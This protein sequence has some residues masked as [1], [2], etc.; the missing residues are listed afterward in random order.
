MQRLVINL[1]GPPEI[2]L[3]GESLETDRHKAIGLL[4]YLATEDKTNSREAL[5]ALLWPDYPQQ[6]AFSYLRRT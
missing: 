2:K 3:N 4:A 5:A 6:S 1:M